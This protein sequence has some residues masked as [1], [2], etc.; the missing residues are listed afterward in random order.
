M[1]RNTS[2]KKFLVV[3]AALLLCATLVFAACSRNEFTPVADPQTSEPV[4]NGGIA[5]T[6]GDWLYYINGYQSD[7]NADNTY[8]DDAVTTPRLG[9]VVRVK[10]SDITEMFKIQD[11]VNATDK[12]DKIEQYVRDHAEVVVPRFYYSG[13]TTTTQYTGLYIFGDR[14]YVTTPNT[15]LTPNGDAQTDQLWLT[16]YKLNGSDEQRHFKFT[17]NT[18]QIYL[19]QKDN[20]VCATYLMGSKLY[21][22]DVASGLSKEVTVNGEDKAPAVENSYTSA[23]WDN[24][25]K[26]VF[27]IDKMYNICKLD[28]GAE[29]YN[30]ILENEDKDNIKVHGEGDSAHVEQ[31]KISYTLSSANNGYVWYTKSDSDNTDSN[32]VELFWANADKNNQLA[33]YASSLSGFKGWKEDKVVKTFS[34][35]QDGSTFYGVMVVSGDNTTKTVLSPEYNGSSITVD[36]VEGDKLYYTANSVK[37]VI[38]LND[39]FAA[40]DPKQEGDPYAKSLPSTAGWAAPDFVDNG[41]VHYILSATTSG[42]LN[43]VRFDPND[44]DKSQTSISLLLKAK[45]T[46][47]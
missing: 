18:A 15:D 17:D 8:S 27:F 1:F 6:Y 14:L 21:Y 35:S 32:G 31:G 40:E 41:D 22:L 5:V 36:R 4:G 10:L 44:R 38:D 2:M 45:A 9:S 3:L 13:N 37:F 39:A 7:V 26:C 16:S 20:K 43:I 46:E 30:V 28:F 47:E 12:A 25:G 33:G 11:D 19:M 42:G 24:A 34:K 29:K 23:T